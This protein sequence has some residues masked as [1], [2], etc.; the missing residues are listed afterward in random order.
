[1]VWWQY[2]EVW[3]GSWQNQHVHSGVCGN[4]QSSGLGWSSR[5]KWNASEKNCPSAERGNPSKQHLHMGFKKG[6]VP[7]K[8]A[9]PLGGGG[10]VVLLWILGS[11]SLVHVVCPT[12]CL[13]T[14]QVVRAG[15]PPV[16]PH[17]PP[18][19]HAVGCWGGCASRSSRTPSPMRWS[20]R[21]CPDQ[22]MASRKPVDMGFP[23]TGGEPSAS[24]TYGHKHIPV[25]HRHIIAHTDSRHTRTHTHINTHA[26][27]Y[28]C[29]S[30][31]I[32]PIY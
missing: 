4:L 24:P 27:A 14:P 6:P 21:F 20:R 15:R 29:H 12:L 32:L 26:P 23:F 1:M 30:V 9:W 7:N 16:A 22:A 18:I 11:L 17:R 8:S 2:I 10:R 5:L 25:T 3:R 19:C 13:V 28:M 31:S